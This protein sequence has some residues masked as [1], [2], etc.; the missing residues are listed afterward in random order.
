MENSWSK[1]GVASEED[2][3]G[4]EGSRARNIPAGVGDGPAVQRDAE[5]RQ[6]P[7]CSAIA[8][9]PSTPDPSIALARAQLPAINSLARRQRRG[10]GHTLISA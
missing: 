6:G 7:G 8:W 10:S 2:V 5:R 1:T 3:G 9:E 4:A